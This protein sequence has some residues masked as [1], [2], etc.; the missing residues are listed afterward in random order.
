MP[1]SPLLTSEETSNLILKIVSIF[2]LLIM[3][4]SFGVLPYFIKSFK[5]SPRLLGTA[6]GFSG[7][8]FKRFPVD[9][10]PGRDHLGQEE[11]HGALRLL[12]DPAVSR[13]RTDQVAI[14]IHVHADLD[15]AQGFDLPL[16]EHLSELR[17]PFPDLVKAVVGEE[18]IAPDQRGK[19]RHLYRNLLVPDRPHDPLVPDI[20][21]V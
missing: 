11:K 16:L 4:F 19:I 2:V 1:L 13:L 7:G 14:H 20:I 17:A 18:R 9:P 3:A 21:Q 5:N 12:P 15:D 10:D 8:L 6:N